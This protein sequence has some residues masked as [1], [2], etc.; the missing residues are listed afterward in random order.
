MAIKALKCPNCGGVIELFDEN[1]KKGF[2]PF[3]DSL[4]QD[5]QERQ[6][7]FVKIIGTIKVE[8]L[9]NIENLIIRANRFLQENDYV[10]AEEYANRALDLDANCSEANLLLV[11]I[12]ERE[13]KHNEVSMLVNKAK[14][15]YKEK[16][17]EQV[18]NLVTRILEVDPHNNDLPEITQNCDRFRRFV[19]REK[20][21][22]E[23][24]DKINSQKLIIMKSG[25]RN[26]K[27]AEIELRELEHRLIEF[28]DLYE[29]YP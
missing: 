29:N 15:A 6:D 17:F 5:I 24:R 1:M 26:R 19:I 20:E 9:A 10:R 27:L 13:N 18:L 28:R 25:G 4:I 3:C 16:R 7:N 2:C 23:L 8:G 12:K 21:Y 14:V 11:T 22:F